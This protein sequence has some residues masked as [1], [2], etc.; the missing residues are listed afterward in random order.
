M[1]YSV[2]WYYYSEFWRVQSPYHDIT[3][4][5]KPMFYE[6]PESPLAYEDIPRNIMLGQSIKLSPNIKK[7]ITTENQKDSFFFPK[8]VWCNLFDNFCID[9]LNDGFADLFVNPSKIN[10]HLREGKIIPYQ[11]AIGQDNSI[12][13]T[14]DDIQQVKIN[15]D[16]A[17]K[18]SGY[19]HLDDGI[20]LPNTLNDTF[21]YIESNL[22][23]SLTGKTFTFTALVK[24]KKNEIQISS[25]LYTILKEVEVLNAFEQNMNEDVDTCK[26]TSNGVEQDC[27]GDTSYTDDG[28]GVFKVN[29]GNITSYATNIT[30]TVVFV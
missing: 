30:L 17:G 16:K 21:A 15:L 12:Y 27:K 10:L 14:Y 3:T 2:L 20:S 8:G 23:A 9:Q 26:Y 22:A 5:F 7:G 18:A 1:K 13:E 4:F 29:F 25:Y 28:S 24:A 11:N 19:L 6:F